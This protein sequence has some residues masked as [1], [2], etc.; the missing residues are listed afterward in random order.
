MSE[1]PPREPIEDAVLNEFWRHLSADRGASNYTQRNY[2]QTLTEFYRWHVNERQR[3]PIWTELE[4]DDFRAYLR[5]LG[6]N[7]WSWLARL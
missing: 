7:L 3:A 1:K 5:W 2:R 6:R 4:R